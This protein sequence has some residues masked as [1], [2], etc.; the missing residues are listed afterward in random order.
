MRIYVDTSVFGGCFDPE[1]ELWSNQLID[2]FMIGKHKAVISEVTESELKFAPGH[3]SKVLSN[4]PGK[5]LEIVK[6]SK[7]AAILSEHY[8]REK[9]VSKKS[10]PDTQHIAAATIEKVD[11]LVSWNFKHIVNY[12]KIRLYNSVNLKFGY[13]VLEIR[14]PRDLIHEE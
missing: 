14:N 6:F 12:D 9:I 7:E 11:L 3:V 8:I 5:N 10:L 4:I 1:F 13:S 2:L